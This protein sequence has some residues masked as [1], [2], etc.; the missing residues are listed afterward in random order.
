MIN[1]NIFTSVVKSYYSFLAIE[2]NMTIIDE[3][4]RGN[5]FY[6]IQFGDNLKVI[7]ISYENVEGYFQIIIYKLH[8]GILSNYD[9]KTNTL[10]LNS[11]NTDTF[12]TLTKDQLSENNN[13]FSGLFSHS[14]IESKL[15]KSAKELRLYLKY[16][17]N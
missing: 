17:T 3:K 4:I 7:S 9:D 14:E 10:N 8:N 2:F 11:L 13:F 1:G 16:H 12:K 15:L 5:A 6:D